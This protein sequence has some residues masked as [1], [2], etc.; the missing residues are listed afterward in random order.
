MT[1]SLVEHL[2]FKV[3]YTQEEIERNLYQPDGEVDE[4]TEKVV[5]EMTDDQKVLLTLWRLLAHGAVVAKSSSTLAVSKAERDEAK[6]KF[7]DLQSKATVIRG[8]FW[9]S[10]RD[11]FDL[12]DADT[13]AFRAGYKIITTTGHGLGDLLD[14]IGSARVSVVEV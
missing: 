9:T 3:P 14:R 5:G 2:P 11:H 7:A 1:S 13:V 12:W 4:E 6:V 8:M 10:I